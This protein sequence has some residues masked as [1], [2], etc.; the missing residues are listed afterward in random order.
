VSLMTLS[1]KSRTRSYGLLSSKVSQ[2]LTEISRTGRALT[3]QERSLLIKGLELLDKFIIGSRLVAG[4]DFK[5]GIIRPTADTLRAYRYAMTT[6]RALQEV[7]NNDE[8][9]KVLREIREKLS[10][11][12]NASATDE[13]DPEDFESLKW[14]FTTLATSLCDD[15]V[16]LRFER[17]D[18][19][20]AN[21]HH[22]SH[23]VGI[24]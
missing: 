5:D 19:S 4:D 11:V 13:I 6:L 20:K 14:F 23:S 10:G 2:T 12:L 9:S 18:G 22:F 8:A 3:E 15:I 24:R 21:A 16:E 1:E 7:R 17:R